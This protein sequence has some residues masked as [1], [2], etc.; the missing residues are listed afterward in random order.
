MAEESAPI[1][2]QDKSNTENP[3]KETGG[4]NPPV[5]QEKKISEIPAR[6]NELHHEHHKKLL[7]LSEISL[8]LDTYEDIF[9]DFDPRDYSRRGLSED[10]ITEVKKASMEKPF[11]G[12]EIR[13]MI[14]K[15]K[16]DEE[17]ERVIRERLKS[18]FGRHAKKLG[19]EFSRAVLNGRLFVLSG[20]LLMFIATYLA[21]SFGDQSLLVQ[22]LIVLTEP[23]GWFLFW[24][25]S[26]IVLFES[27]KLRPDV[28]FY[29]KLSKGEI[30]FIGY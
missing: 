22:F 9:S 25:G 26:N 4:S 2:Q 24:E 29:E 20:L 8:S 11:G 6:E 15:D 23:A 19:T 5:Q 27:K 10:F 28:E 17:H 21:F 16:R 14:P 30:E 7:E 12:I 13:L 3:A 18:H 1:A